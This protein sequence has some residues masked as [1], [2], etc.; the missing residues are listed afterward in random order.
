MSLRRGLKKERDNQ[1]FYRMNENSP[2]TTIVPSLLG[3]INFIGAN[4]RKA[5]VLE[6]R[7]IFAV[8]V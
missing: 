4:E 8:T 3:R 5:A 1:F 2:E 7:G 6:N